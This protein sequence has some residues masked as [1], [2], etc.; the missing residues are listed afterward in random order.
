VRA[1]A[2]VGVHSGRGRGS[3]WSYQGV[4]RPLLPPGPVS[5]T[6]S[7]CF[8]SSVGSLTSLSLEFGTGILTMAFIRPPL[9]P[10]PTWPSTAVV[11]HRCYSEAGGSGLQSNPVPPSKPGHSKRECPPVFGSS[12]FRA[13]HLWV[14]TLKVCLHWAEAIPSILWLVHVRPV[15]PACR[16]Q[17]S[18]YR[19]LWADPVTQRSSRREV[20]LPGHVP[21]RLPKK[22]GCWCVGCLFRGLGVGCVCV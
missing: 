20:L 1:R 12:R 10:L 8:D 6:T 3:S 13:H 5:Y 14:S 15:V 17:S 18:L 21:P 19:S 4:Y 11:F 9:V 7:S 22:W 2:R 16:H